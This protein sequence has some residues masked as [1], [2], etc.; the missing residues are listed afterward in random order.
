MGRKI[1]GFGPGRVGPGRI[2]RIFPGMAPNGPGTIIWA[3]GVLFGGLGGEGGGAL[4]FVGPI[5][6]ESDQRRVLV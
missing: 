3:L 2:F 5:F 1:R 6:P 4:G